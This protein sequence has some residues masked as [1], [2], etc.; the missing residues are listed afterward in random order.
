MSLTLMERAIQL[1]V[2]QTARE[3]EGEVRR[4]DTYMD[5]VKN[6]VPPTHTTAVARVDIQRRKIR[7]I[8]AAGMT[9]DGTKE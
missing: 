8:T 6:I 4:T 1:T 9:G 2:V 7:L 3:K 5:K